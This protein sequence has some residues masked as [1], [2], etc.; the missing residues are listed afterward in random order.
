MVCLGVAALLVFLLWSPCA[1]HRPTLTIAVD[2]ATHGS[3]DPAVGAHTYDAGEVVTITATPASGYGFDHWSGAVT[4]VTN[5]VIVTMNGNKTVTANFAAM[6]STKPDL[7][8]QDITWVPTTPFPGDTVALSVAVKN[9]GA[10]TGPF[11]VCLIVDD[12]P[13][14]SANVSSV[15]SNTVSIIRSFTWIAQAGSH[16]FK[17]VA[18]CNN[19]VLENDETNN[20]TEVTLTVAPVLV[21][22]YEGFEGGNLQN[23]QISA[24]GAVPFSVSQDDAYSGGHALKIGPSSCGESCFDAYKVTL[25]LSGKSFPEGEYVVSC[26]RREPNDWGGHLSMYINGVKIGDDLGTYSNAHADSG[27]YE[28]KFAYTGSIETLV[29]EETDLTNAESIFL[30]DIRVATSA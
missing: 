21:L 1:T 20:T 13:Q 18:D 23:W 3:T 2:D 8:V 9:E 5:P 16:T 27:W 12:V 29:F 10:D 19:A 22:F 30:D 28:V 24:A 25:T 14:S 6:A 17:A 11:D 26:Y 4:G 15:S 7:R